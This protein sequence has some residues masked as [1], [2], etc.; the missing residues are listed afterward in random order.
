LHVTHPNFKQRT[1]TGMRTVKKT[2]S[3]NC[4]MAA[5]LTA[6]A[7]A[8]AIAEAGALKLLFARQ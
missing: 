8:N 7:A 3:A 2:E 4:F 1:I 5:M 6:I